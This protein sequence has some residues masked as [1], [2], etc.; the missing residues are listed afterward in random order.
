MDETNTPGLGGGLSGDIFGRPEGAAIEFAE[1]IFGDWLSLSFSSEGGIS[2]TTTMISE[3]AGYVNFL[4]YILIVVIMSYVLIAAVIKTASEGKVM[5]NGWSSV[6]L[7]L[8]TFLACF[9]IFPV[10]IGQAST[11]SAVQVSVAWLGMVGSNAADEVAKYAITNIARRVNV[12]NPEVGGFR[13]IKDVTQNAICAF[14]LEA[15]DPTGRGNTIEMLGIVP[16]TNRFGF[17]TK[18]SLPVNSALAGHRR[19]EFGRNGVC[20]SIEVKTDNEELRRALMAKLLDYQRLAFHDIAVP[21]LASDAE[22]GS[23][24]YSYRGG[25]NVYSSAIEGYDSTSN[26][27]SSNDVLQRLYSVIDKQL[28][29]MTSYR[30]EVAEIIAEHMES[31]NNLIIFEADSAGNIMAKI[32]PSSY[33]DAGWPYLG[34]YYSVISMSLR[35][36]HDQSH[37]ASN[38]ISS[39]HIVDG[40]RILNQ[41]RV[42]ERSLSRQIR[43]REEDCL[44]NDLFGVTEILTAGAD[45][46][47]SQ[48][49]SGEIE[50]VRD[51][52][53]SICTGSSNCSPEKIESV[54][55]NAI[56]SRFLKT[57][58][59]VSN[60]TASST[61]L[62]AISLLG[63]GLD[64]KE[65]VGFNSIADGY[66]SS[67]NYNGIWLLPDPIHFTSSLGTNIIVVNTVWQ[68]AK[69]LIKGVADGVGN[70]GGA[71]PVISGV[72][73]GLGSI[74]AGFTAYVDSMM[75]PI[76][77]SA[78]GMA[79]LIPM[80][81]TLIWVM[82]FLSWLLMYAEAIFNAPLAVTLMATPEGEGI[83]GARMERKLAMLAAL[84]LKPVFLIVGLLLS[85]VILTIGFVFM[86]QLFWLSAANVFGDRLFPIA[87][88]ITIWFGIIT[89]FMH[90]TFKIIMTFPDD[91]LEWFLGGIAR[92]FGNNLDNNT[93]DKFDNSNSAAQGDP[94]T[95]TGSS[96]GIFGNRAGTKVGKMLSN[97][98]K[99]SE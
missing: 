86:N 41:R 30:A 49:N 6:W 40:C 69:I 93:I 31:E 87:A 2:G 66:D 16:S 43:D 67:G 72:A 84:V 76:V 36:I 11:I 52:L 92:Q 97:R 78:F 53:D 12:I 81:P 20:G 54:V 77:I 58:E 89:V 24:N 23:S 74:I 63:W 29:M 32:N 22:N 38:S 96:V 33:G 42:S 45:R 15:A 39:R 65:H 85:M 1:L 75:R 7:P 50:N 62:G 26:T 94:T 91:S 8:R 44:F 51:A 14:S 28:E 95:I 55:G 71:L 99:A 90:N 17:S 57:S 46:V 18:E 19:V 25:Y 60:S 82:A 68:N 4:A 37:L 73:A 70:A 5:G 88:L 10:G 83:A 98:N 3:V 48:R 35:D 80:L 79:Y 27:E 47:I 64:T 59:A 56:S 13:A 34:A 61:A 21:L 9:L